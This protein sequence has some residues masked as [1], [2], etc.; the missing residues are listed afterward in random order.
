MTF[1]DGRDPTIS[2]RNSDLAAG[3][4]AC[5]NKVDQPLISPIH[6]NFNP[7]FPPVLITTG[8]RDLLL[9]Q[10]VRLS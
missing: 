6:G 4:Y 1:N 8:T 5:S 10:A 2:R 7:S 3:Y 9:S